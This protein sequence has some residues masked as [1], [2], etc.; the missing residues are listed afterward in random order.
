MSDL[1]DSQRDALERLLDYGW[2]WQEQSSEP[3]GIRYGQADALVEHG[4]ATRHRPPQG[5]TIVKPTDDAQEL[6]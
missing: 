1:T 2:L 6:L 4:W 3:M 5:K